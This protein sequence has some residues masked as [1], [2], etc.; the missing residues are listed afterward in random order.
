MTK[1]TSAYGFLWGNAQ[2]AYT[3]ETNIFCFKNKREL[4][5]NQVDNI[6]QVCRNCKFDTFHSKK[7]FENDIKRGEKFLDKQYLQRFI[8]GME[9]QFKKHWQLFDKVK[10]TDMKKVSDEELLRYFD[11]LMDAWVDIIGYFRGT[12]AEGSQ[13]LAKELEKQVPKEQIAILMISPDMDIANKEQLGW[14]EIVK[15]CPINKIPSEKELLEHAAKYPWAVMCHSSYQEVID[16]LRQR[17]THD[18][19]IDMFKDIKEE[20]RKIKREQDAII[21]KNP[22]IKSIVTTIHRLALSR[23]EVKSCWAGNDFYFIPIF[24]EIEKRTGES[25]HDIFW[26]YLRQEIHDLFKGKR[27][28]DEEKKCR[29]QCFVGLWKDGNMS[30]YSGKK[31]VSVAKRE[32]KELFEPKDCRVLQGTI[33]NPGNVRG[34]ARILHSNNREETKYMRKDFKKGEILITEMT[35]PSV[36]DIASKASA[37]VTDEGGMLS[38]AAIISRELKIPCIVGTGM[39]TKIIKDG[40]RIEVDAKAGSVKILEKMKNNKVLER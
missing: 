13:Y 9:K 39:A 1:N 4:D 37:L 11:Q 26:Y 36:M 6:I 15:K 21:K 16:T 33:A 38:H 10:Q 20:K 24:A 34:I 7:D 27:V 18:K 2:P 14:Q 22:K 19:G 35:Q 17:Y 25:A 32:L 28:S 5:W 23:M 31:A 12:Q 40:D 8:E 29:R 30:L 3:L